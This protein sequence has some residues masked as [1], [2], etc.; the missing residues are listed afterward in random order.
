MTELR[1]H[2]QSS[3]GRYDL[4]T[5][6]EFLHCANVET[7]VLE[8]AKYRH[9]KGVILDSVF[10][11]DKSS[12][13]REQ[14]E[15]IEKLGIPLFRFMDSYLSGDSQDRQLFQK[16][17]E[18]FTRQMASHS[19]RGLRADDRK[20]CFARLERILDRNLPVSF[21]GNINFESKEREKVVTF[22]LSAR[23]CFI[24]L[25]SHDIKQGDEILLSFE[26][27][28]TAVVAKVRWLNAWDGFKGRM[29]GVG[30]E[31]VAYP[32][33]FEAYI[34]KLLND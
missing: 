9:V 29:P 5:S 8:I 22:D 33:S 25:C 16:K 1:N 15:S 12:F 11:V 13:V 31:F 24:V 26:G 28:Q 10:F 14:I 19:P 6:V 20:V 34:S 23:G 17:W 4:T 7:L 32:K 3:L 27:C 18:V 21:E 2:V 30:V